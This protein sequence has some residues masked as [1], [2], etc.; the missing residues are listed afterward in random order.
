MIQT[1]IDGTA[2]LAGSIVDGLNVASSLGLIDDV[3]ALIQFT[4]RQFAGIVPDVVIEEIG[5]DQLRITDHPVEIGAAITDHAFKLPVELDMKCGFSDSTAGQVGYVRRIYDE[6][7]NLQADREPFTLYAGKRVY[8]NML[9]AGLVQITDAKAENALQLTIRFRE[10][11]LTYTTQ[12]GSGSQNG[13]TPN[14]NGVD[15]T[16]G[17]SDKGISNSTSFFAERAGI[18]PATNVGSLQPIGVAGAPTSTQMFSQMAGI[19]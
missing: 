12:Q 3:G 19:R 16:T 11:I 2:L 13:T 1:I 7:V 6:L 14:S 15:S 9:M 17:M 18:L 4:Q 10:I 8:K 5:N